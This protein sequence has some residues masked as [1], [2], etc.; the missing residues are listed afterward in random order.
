MRIDDSEGKGRGREGR[1]RRKEKEAEEEGR[2]EKEVCRH[3]HVCVYR[4]IEI[5]TEKREI[6]DNFCE[7]QQQ[8][9]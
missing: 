6:A 8:F 5:H 7:V 1:M 9:G 2:E 4:N 3:T